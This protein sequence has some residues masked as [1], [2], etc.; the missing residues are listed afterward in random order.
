MMNLLILLV[1][2]FA[3]IAI[4]RLMKVYEL[5]AELKGET[6]EKVKQK[7][8]RFNA[9]MMIG[10]LVFIF[11]FC[12]FQLVKYS[13]VIL[14]ESASEHGVDVDNLMNFNLIIISIVFVA[15]NFLLFYFASKYY[16]RPGNKAT[17]VSHN[18]KL[19]MVWTVIP[20]IVLS[21]IIIY[22]LTTWNKITSAVEGEAINIELYAK[23]FDWTARYEG[24]DNVLGSYDY[25]LTSDTNPLAL[26][27]EDKANND[28]ILVKGEFHIPVG[29]EV[30]FNFRSRDVI[31]SAYM[32]H[33]R[34]QMNCVPGM[35][36]NFHFKPILTTAEMR[37]KLNNPDFNY[38]LLCNKICGAA[39]YN[40][41][42][43]IIVE[44]PEEY[45]K[46]LAEQK[47]FAMSNV[48]APVE[49]VKTPEVKVDSLAAAPKD[50][51]K[52]ATK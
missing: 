6:E 17:F 3:I 20:A 25:R 27:T 5:T 49:E 44:T 13:H 30:M 39:H 43:D 21:V 4:L 38:I 48:V 34:A 41:Q 14:P 16:F 42:M 37:K 35:I 26:V 40:M 12:I 51:V 10:A 19:E 32:P 46:W 1:V 28:D 50:T 8:I 29:K 23:Q 11:G 15:T 31:H 24:K 9:G 18:N 33:F 45:N 52:L 36:T 47:T 2:V 7:D 22:G